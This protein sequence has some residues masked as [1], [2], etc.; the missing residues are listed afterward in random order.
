V[1]RGIRIAALALAAAL[2]LAIIFH[3]WVLSEMASYLDLGMPPQKADLVY[4]L[5]GDY[6]GNRVLKGGELVREG[7]A[8][9]A[10]VSGPSGT[11]GHYESDLAIPFAEQNGYPASYFVAF[12]NHALST[13]DEAMAAVEKMREMGAHR[14][15][16]VTNPYHSRRALM[17]FRDVAP[18]MTIT[19]VDAPDE[20]FT[21]DG[22]WRDRE[23]RKIFLIEW[24]KTFA[25]WFRI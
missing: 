21:V 22:W 13:R 8:P 7:Y 19:V 12:P 14:V 5:A 17:L 4:V 23:G 25:G 10:L 15:L 20:H 3:G 11:Y 24:L 6:A 16:I 9:R 2:V 1:R 18:D